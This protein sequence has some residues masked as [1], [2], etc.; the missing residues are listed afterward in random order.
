MNIESHREIISHPRFQDQLLAR[1]RQHPDIPGRS[2]SSTQLLRLAYDGQS[3]LNWVAYTGLTYE[4]IAGLLGS[5]ELRDAEA[6]S[7]CIDH[8]GG[9][10]TPLLMAL[11]ESRTIRDICFLQGPARANDDKTSQLFS[12]ICEL[13]SIST[14]GL[15]G[16]SRSG[17]PLL[18]SKNLFLT[19]AFSAP[20]RRKFW[21]LDPRGGRLSDTALIRSFPVQHMFVRQQ[22]VVGSLPGSNGGDNDT[23]RFRP[24]H[25][26]LGDALLKPERLAASF[27][28]YCRSVLTDRFL[29]SFAAV[30]SKAPSES[31]GGEFFKGTAISPIPAENLA[32]PEQCSVPSATTSAAQVECWPLFQA[33]EPN[34]W[35]LLVSHEWYTAPDTRLRREELVSRGLPG[36]SSLGVPF[37]RY[38]F[39]RARRRIAWSDIA[40][41]DLEAMVRPECVEIVGGVKEFLRETTPNADGGSVDARMD[42]AVRV[43]RKRWP[44]GLG[45][46][47]DFISLLDDGTAR[48]ILKDFLRDTVYVRKNLKMAMQAMPQGELPVWEDATCLSERL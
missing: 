7:I 41:S 15:H 26:F 42:D 48:S 37:V 1:L 14:R 46:D 22:L 24:C 6:L 43:F 47:M 17:N 36:D 44:A 45:P 3:H 27:L 31:P 10:P 35:V 32:I 25:F 23:N 11:S 9:Y 38:A 8:V 18:S 20:L 21:L 29:F 12:Q 40:G 16:T 30:P 33:I 39:L 19:C 4:N 34:G 2:E 13:P 5:A 28:Q